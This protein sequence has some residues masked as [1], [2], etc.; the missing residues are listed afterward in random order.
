MKTWTLATM[1]VMGLGV[2]LVSSESDQPHD[3]VTVLNAVRNLK[4]LIR[5]TDKPFKMDAVAS[6]LCAAPSSARRDPNDVHQDYYCHVYI[7]KA[8]LPVMKSG[9]G[10]YPEGTVVVKQKFADQ[11]A[12]TVELYTAMRKRQPGYDPEH[13]DWEYSVVNAKATKVLSRGRTDSCIECHQPYAPTD[14]ITR[15]YLSDEK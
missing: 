9:E 1:L 6:T 7:S 2:C 4:E 15:L 14:Y 5:V 8:G 11:R 13:G 10:T 3:G 12:K